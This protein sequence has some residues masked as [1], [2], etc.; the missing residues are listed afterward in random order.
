MIEMLF[1]GLL[2]IFSLILSFSVIV[3]V[4]LLIISILSIIYM[5]LAVLILWLIPLNLNIFEL[6][7]ILLISH[8]IIEEILNKLLDK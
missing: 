6:S 7:V 3:G 8:V 2:T 4:V 1:G 5:P